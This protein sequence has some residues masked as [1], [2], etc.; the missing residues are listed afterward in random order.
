[1]NLTIP[2]GQTRTLVLHLTE[3]AGSGPPIVRLPPLINAFPSPQ[4]AD[5][6]CGS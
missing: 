5:A 6:S 2:A 1:M 3:P 4:I